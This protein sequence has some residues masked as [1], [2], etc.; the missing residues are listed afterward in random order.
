MTIVIIDYQ[1]GNLHSIEKAVVAC[2][3]R[4]GRNRPVLLSQDIDQIEQ[5]SHI[6]LPGVGAF[7]D[8]LHGIQ[9]VDGLVNALERKV[10]EQ[11]TP[12]LGICV[13]MQLLASQGHENGTHQGLGW[14]KGSVIPINHHNQQYRI[15]HMGWNVIEAQKNHPVLHG[16]RE[17]SHVYFVHSYHFLCDNVQE[18]IATVS[19]G[20][21][22]TAIIAKDHIIGVQFHPEKSQ[23]VGLQVIDNF[24]RM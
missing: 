11:Q 4:S 9:A 21:A 12:F 14:I 5:A 19:Y 16:V 24:L 20:E 1:S 23:Q 22:L 8:C 13:G 6:I 17:D 10:L 2:E 15:P 3:E 7:A 18:Q